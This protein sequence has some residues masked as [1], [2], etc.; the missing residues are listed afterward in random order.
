LTLIGQSLIVPRFLLRALCSRQLI[1]ATTHSPPIH[2]HQVNNLGAPRAFRAQLDTAVRMQRDD[3]SLVTVWTER[4]IE[5]RI[6]TA[7]DWFG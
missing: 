7:R 4:S 6:R 5:P 1:G 3:D 2:V